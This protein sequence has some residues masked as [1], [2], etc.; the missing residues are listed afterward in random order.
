MRE[1]APHHEARAPELPVVAEIGQELYRANKRR[2]RLR[3][4][5]GTA[6]VLSVTAVGGAA[7][8]FGS[9]GPGRSDL[10]HALNTP[11]IVDGRTQ[12]AR[13]SVLADSQGRYCL[14]IVLR[15]T[16]TRRCERSGIGAR[17]RI[18]AAQVAAGEYGF[19]YG[20]TGDDV[21]H[22]AVRLDDGRCA[23]AVTHRGP[24]KPRDAPASRLRVY[25]AAFRRPISPIVPAKRTHGRNPDALIRVPR[26]LL[27]FPG[28]RA[29][30][31]T[32]STAQ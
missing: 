14:Q 12:D 23:T 19:V 27:R 8:A 5:L 21:Q 32:C 3:Q 22:V 20:I 9:Y 2:E 6:L 4:R 7:L 31:G 29:S 28:G 10:P 11:K 1:D 13:W 18:S 15:S 25:V 16:T 30:E 26:A 24:R 17:G